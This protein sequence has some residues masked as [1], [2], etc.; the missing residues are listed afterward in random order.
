M[1]YATVRTPT[2]DNDRL[3]VLSGEGALHCLRST[4]GKVLWKTTYVS[5]GG[6]RFAWGWGD[7]PLVDGNLLICVPGGPRGTVAALNKMTGKVVWQCALNDRVHAAIVPAEIGNIRQYVVFGYERVSGVVAR[8]GQLAWQAERKG[9]T[10][11]I[12]TP[13]V[14]DGFVVVSSGFAVGTN[15]FKVEGEAGRFKVA[16][17]WSGHQLDVQSGGMARVGDHLYALV[18]QGS[19]KC[20]E[21]KTGS[22]VW[23]NRSVGKG[24]VLVADGRLICRGEAGSVALVDPSVEGYREKGRFAGPTRGYD[25]ARSQPVV[26]GGRLYLRAEGTLYCYDLRGPGFKEPPAVWTIP[27][28]LPSRP[29]PSAPPAP[30]PFAVFVPTPQDVVERMLELAGVTSDDAVYDLGSGDGRI[31]IAAAKK[32]GCKAVGYEIQ[33]ILVGQSRAKVRE[34]GLVDQVTI[35]EKDLFKAD[36]SAATVVTLYLGERN[37]AKLL[38]QLSKLKAGARIVSHMHL[39]GKDGPKP[40][41]TVTMVSKEDG[42]EHAIHLWTAPLAEK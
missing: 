31:L 15:A 38:P 26:A 39:L 14:H 4:D 9:Q 28:S 29:P 16:P 17:V 33:P 5:L 32:Y 8:T 25:S 19:L 27:A 37:N 12:S 2:V 18:D 23:Q 42:S 21:L 35:E 10:A 11:V 30:E 34:A 40:Q 6:E 22:E 13:I 24:S 3:Y 20:V 7:F 1:R 36:L 41:K